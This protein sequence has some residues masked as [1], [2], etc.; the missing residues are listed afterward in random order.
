MALLFSIV[1]VCG[2][3]RG[4]PQNLRRVNIRVAEGGGAYV[5]A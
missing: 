3:V 5:A 1:V 4:V 2:A